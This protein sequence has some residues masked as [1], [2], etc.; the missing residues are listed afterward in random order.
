MR[1]AREQ[2][3]LFLHRANEIEV[4]AKSETDE[5][6]QGTLLLLAEYY[7]QLV[8]NIGQERPSADTRRENLPSRR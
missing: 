6:L 8:L 2:A 3:E 5:Q 1:T 7:R 4:K